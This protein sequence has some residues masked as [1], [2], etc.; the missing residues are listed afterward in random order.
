MLPRNLYAREHGSVRVL[1]HLLSSACV[2]PQGGD[3]IAPTHEA[4]EQKA[5]KSSKIDFHPRVQQD[6]EEEVVGRVAE[7]LSHQTVR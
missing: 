2:C 1:N 7:G 6:I 3:V 4:H 5:R